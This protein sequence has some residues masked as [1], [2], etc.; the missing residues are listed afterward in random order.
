[1]IV[2]ADENA[3]KENPV[4]PVDNAMRGMGIAQVKCDIPNCNR[5]TVRNRSKR[6]GCFF[7][8]LLG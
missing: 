6:P 3:Q 5:M 1:M 7:V 4:V 2:P 8:F